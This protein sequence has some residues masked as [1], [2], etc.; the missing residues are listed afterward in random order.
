MLF[1]LFSQCSSG[2]LTLP[3]SSL[4]I[5]EISASQASFTAANIVMIETTQSRHTCSILSQ[6]LKHT[7]HMFSS[8]PRGFPSFP[9]T[10]VVLL[11]VLV[12]FLAPLLISPLLS[13]NQ[14]LHSLAHRHSIEKAIL[15]S[16]QNVQHLLHRY[17][18]CQ[19]SLHV[20]L[21]LFFHQ[22]QSV[23]Q[24]V[25]QCK[26]SLETRRMRARPPALATSSSYP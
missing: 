5:G 21:G 18:L 8:C 12:L 17:L 6:I 11:N 16:I 1:H 22:R 14:L 9:H 15:H 25:A 3:P 23:F 24:F 10:L 20:F 2:K 19:I 26:S 7:S 13:G 4:K